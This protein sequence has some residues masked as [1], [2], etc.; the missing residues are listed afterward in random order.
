MRLAALALPV[1]FTG[2][3]VEPHT[4][5]RAALWCHPA[6]GVSVVIDDME[7]GDGKL[8][9][10]ATGGPGGSWQ[11]IVVD[12]N[13]SGPT[14]SPPAGPIAQSAALTAATLPPA[15]AQSTRGLELTGA[16]FTQASNASAILAADFA[17][18]LALKGTFSSVQF[19]AMA[20]RPTWLR[21]NVA[22]AADPATGARWGLPVELGT[23]WAQVIVPLASLSAE[24]MAAP[25]PDLTAA[26]AIEFKYSY[27]L[28]GMSGQQD[29]GAAAGAFHVWI[30][31]VQL[32]P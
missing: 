6:D 4:G 14:V 19:W 10:P 16:G 9:T 2:A 3:C 1:L 31:D 25:A 21:L 11:V 17:A 13:A 22:T 27:F 20:D 12:P 18:P 8:C 30:D 32:T 15:L 5:T 28:S 29:P 23:G 24:F 26:S 7:D